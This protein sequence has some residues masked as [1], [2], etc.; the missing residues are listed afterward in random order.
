MMQQTR[1]LLATALTAFVLVMVGGIA[2]AVA[3]HRA[4]P[5]APAAAQVSA[6][7]VAP[8][9]PVAGEPEQ[10][11]SQVHQASATTEP[12]ASEDQER[13]GNRDHHG[14]HDGNDGD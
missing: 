6:P 10:V 8:R 2:G 12:A 1:M 5:T 11:P 4:V 14:E 3:A 13:P 9:P 7:P